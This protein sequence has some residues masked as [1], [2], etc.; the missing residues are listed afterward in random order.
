MFS[1]LGVGI[2]VGVPCVFCFF[3]DGAEGSIRT[4]TSSCVC[5]CL[6]GVYNEVQVVCKYGTTTA[7]LSREMQYG[8]IGG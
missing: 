4:L 8:V 7:L 5:G 2:E 3:G 1:L 6:G